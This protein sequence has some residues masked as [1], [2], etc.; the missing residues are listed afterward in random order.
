MGAVT[1]TSDASTETPVVAHLPRPQLFQFRNNRVDELIL[2]AAGEK[3]DQGRRRN[4]KNCGLLAPNWWDVAVSM[5]F[6][7]A[8]NHNCLRSRISPRKHHQ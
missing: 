8:V 1:V 6:E 2:A 3:R 7:A 4:E 5:Q